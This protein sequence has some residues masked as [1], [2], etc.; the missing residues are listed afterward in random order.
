MS[1][2]HETTT[3]SH[4]IDDDDQLLWGARAIGSAINQSPSQVFPMLH[5][6][7]IKCAVKRNG[8]WTAWRKILRAEFGLAEARQKEALTEIDARS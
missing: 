5:H 6:G 3:L 8:R 2:Q 4:T 7:R 1:V